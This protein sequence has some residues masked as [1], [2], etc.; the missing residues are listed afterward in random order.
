MESTKTRYH[1]NNYYNTSPIKLGDIRLLQIGRRFCDP[2]EIIRPHSHVGWYELTI[3]TG[4]EGSVFTAGTPTAVRAGDI[5]LSFPGDIHEIRADRGEKL[6]YDFFSFFCEPSKIADDLKNATRGC[7]REC[8]R[9]LRDSRI[10]H[11]IKWAMGE[12]ND[13][14][15][16]YREDML[17]SAFSMVLVYLVRDLITRERGT[18]D[19]NEAEILCFRIMNYIDTHIFTL[20]NLE[21]VAPKFNYNYCYLSALFKKTTGKTISEYHSH[22]KM[23]T[24]RVLILEGKKKVSEIAELLGYSPYSFSRAFKAKYG[25]APKSLQKSND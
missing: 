9:V 11:L 20:K 6:E 25:I 19:I 22:K 8:D 3:V 16:G 15:D 2:T 14:H 5:Y 1:I 18:A 21:S 17:T 4:G 10:S 7:I 12:I 23:E 13:T 24:A